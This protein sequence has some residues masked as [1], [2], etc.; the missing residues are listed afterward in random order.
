MSCCVDED[1]NC[2]C[3][4]FMCCKNLINFLFVF[5][6]CFFLMFFFSCFGYKSKCCK[7]KLNILD[8]IFNIV[9]FLILYVFCLCLIILMFIFL[10]WLF[11][12]FVFVVF[13]IRVYILWY[14]M[15]IVIIVVYFIKY[16]YEIVNMNFD[17][18][19]YIFICEENI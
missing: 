11:M 16:F 4:C 17:I 8:C 19:E 1:G 5:M 9:G 18:F 2:N 15:V 14:I 3:K 12:Y 7:D 10:F 6:Y 13:L